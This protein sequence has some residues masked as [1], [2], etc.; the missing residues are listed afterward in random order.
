MSERSQ[1]ATCEPRVEKVFWWVAREVDQ[2]VRISS[3]VFWARRD[4][5]GGAGPAVELRLVVWVVEVGGWKG[6][7]VFAG[8][9]VLKRL[10]IGAAAVVEVAAIEVVAVVWDDGGNSEGVAVA[11]VG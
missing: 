1:V 4:C 9:P 2:V 6:V 10:P 7:V 5:A 3:R 8:P 11:V